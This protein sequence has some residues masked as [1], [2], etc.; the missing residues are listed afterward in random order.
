MGHVDWQRWSRF[1]PPSQPR[2]RVAVGAAPEQPACR[3]C[4]GV[5]AASN[6]CSGTGSSV[7]GIP[8][9]GNS[10][11]SYMEWQ[12]P[13][14]PN[15][16][17]PQCRGAPSTTPRLTPG[18]R[19]SEVWILSVPVRLGLPHVRGDSPCDGAL[20]GCTQGRTPVSTAGLQK[21]CVLETGTETRTGRFG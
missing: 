17:S 7:T 13:G 19:R 15:W 14:A 3:G 12:S 9:V 10:R 5:W 6:L 18:W 8:D 4:G 2:V 1:F 11:S 16:R 20:P 21:V